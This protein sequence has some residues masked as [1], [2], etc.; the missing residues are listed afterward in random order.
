MIE[1][2]CPGCH[3]PVYAPPHRGGAEEA[4]PTSPSEAVVVS[5]VGD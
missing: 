4:L 2:T 3:K 1:F 5:P